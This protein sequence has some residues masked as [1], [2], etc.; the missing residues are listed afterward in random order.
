MEGG[1]GGLFGV[2][3]VTITLTLICFIICINM[4][5]C[6]RDTDTITT[7]IYGCVG[8]TLIVT[9]LTIILICCS[10]C[11]GSGTFLAQVRC[12]VGSYNFC[13][14]RGAPGSEIRF[15]GR[16][17]NSFGDGNFTM[18]DGI[19]CRRLRF[20][21]ATV[22]EG[23]FFCMISISSLSE[24]SILTCLSIIIGSLAIH[25]LGHSNG[26]V[27][28]FIASGTRSN[29]ITLSGVI[30]AFNGGR[31]LG[32]TFTIIRPRGSGYFF[33]KGVRAGYRELITSCVVQSPVPVPSSLV[34]GRHLP[35]RSRLRRRVR[36]FALGS[37]GSNAFCTR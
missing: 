5:P 14:A 27:V 32:V 17:I 28:Y 8:S 16:L 18:G 13:C 3:G 31:R 1:R 4:T 34:R 37:F 20:S 19:R 11:N 21:C 35:F 26:Y 36:R 22:G 25:G 2:V 9:Y 15:V 33:L 29:T 10:G 12:R 7:V 6:V 30:Y 24:S 23:R